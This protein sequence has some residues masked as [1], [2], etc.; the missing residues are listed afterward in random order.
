MSVDDWLTTAGVKSS[1]FMFGKPH[2]P[3]VY[4]MH[5]KAFDEYIAF[6]VSI[7]APRTTEDQFETGRIPPHRHPP[8]KPIR[9]ASRFS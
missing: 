1:L 6:V 2:R 8:P 9:S 3:E 4:S 7:T 5:P